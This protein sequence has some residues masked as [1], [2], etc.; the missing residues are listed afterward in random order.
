M[1]IFHKLFYSILSFVGTTVAKANTC[2]SC[3]SLWYCREC[4]ALY[5]V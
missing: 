4:Y 3:C 5:W 2:D 1:F